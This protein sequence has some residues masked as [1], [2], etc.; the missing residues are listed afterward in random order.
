MKVTTDACLFGAWLTEE[1]KN[2]EIIIDSCLDIGTG[3]G[4]LSLMLVQQNPFLKVDAL[5]IDKDAAGQAEE[6]VIASPWPENITVINADARTFVFEKKYDC[7]FSNPPFY[8]NELKSIDERKN[9]AHHGNDLKLEELIA[10]IKQNINPDGIFFLLLPYKRNDEI[11]N[12]LNDQKFHISKICFVRQ[13]IQHDYFR[14]M[15]KGKLKSKNRVETEIEEI[16]VWDNQQ[17]YTP[18]F[19]DLLKAYYLNL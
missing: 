10:V 1:I 5:E 2:E 12:M 11:K 14:I 16:S 7:I 15:L 3:T 8:E 9:Q 4:L 17:Q 19:K 6:N 18:R 13:S